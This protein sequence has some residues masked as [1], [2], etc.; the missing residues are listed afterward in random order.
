[1]DDY[2]LNG[3]IVAQIFFKIQ[4]FFHYVQS[5][6][7]SGQID[8]TTVRVSRREPFDYNPVL[9]VYVDI[10]QAFRIWQVTK[11]N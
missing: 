7:D 1:M 6:I 3:V 10:T 9:Q 8:N 2:K 11:S 5:Q 4:D